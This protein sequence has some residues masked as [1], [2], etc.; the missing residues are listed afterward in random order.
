MALAMIVNATST[1]TMLSAAAWYLLG[2][3]V[4]KLD[5]SSNRSKSQEEIAKSSSSATHIKLVPDAHLN[6]KLLLYI[7]LKNSSLLVFLTKYTRE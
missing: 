5:S 7:S 4:E 1:S 2:H 3:L 6:S